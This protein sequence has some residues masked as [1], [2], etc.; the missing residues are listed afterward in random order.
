MKRFRNLFVLGAKGKGKGRLSLV[1]RMI[2]EDTLQL[3]L[4][5]GPRTL[6]CIPLRVSR[7]FD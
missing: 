2:G 5:R 1:Y 4:R 3:C 7:P 6:F